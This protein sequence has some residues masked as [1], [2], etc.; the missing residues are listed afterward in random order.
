MG[1]ETQPLQWEDKQERAFKELKGLLGKAPALGL[2]NTGKHFCLYVHEKDKTALGLLTQP[3]GPCG[4]PIMY[5]SKKL[6][7]V[8][9]G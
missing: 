7:P 4:K 8:A 9:S 5:L 3:L 2:P 6:D 1:P